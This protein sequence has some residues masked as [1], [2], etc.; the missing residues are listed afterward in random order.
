MIVD[1]SSSLCFDETIMEETIKQYLARIG[2]KG[3]KATGK[4]K[5][6]GGKAYYSRISKKGWANR[7]SRDEKRRAAK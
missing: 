7:R 3:G 4:S 6:R 5:R 2:G 1:N